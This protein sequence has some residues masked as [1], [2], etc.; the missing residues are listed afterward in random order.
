[1][2]YVLD[3]SVALKWVLLEADSARAIRLRDDHLNGVHELIAPDLSFPKSRTA[4]LQP[5]G[6]VG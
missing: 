4:W 1:M 3:S 2:R 5:N 6:R